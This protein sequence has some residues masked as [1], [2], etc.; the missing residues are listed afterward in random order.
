MEFQVLFD[1]FFKIEVLILRVPG[2][3]MQD[4]IQVIVTA[5]DRNT[6]YSSPT[7]EIIL[8]LYYTMV[9]PEPKK[10]F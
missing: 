7:S 10:V 8:A 4:M 3:G 5:D 6:C 2:P 1:L 9:Y